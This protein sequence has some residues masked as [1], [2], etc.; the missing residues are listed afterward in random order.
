M[1]YIVNPGEYT[2]ARLTRRNGQY[3]MHIIRCG[4]VAR[5]WAYMDWSNVDCEGFIHQFDSNHIN[6]VIW[7]YVA[8]L[9][10]FYQMIG[11]SYELY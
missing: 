3:K 6:C 1:N 5:A 7:D 9:V 11:I 4:F 8:E 2:L 10:D